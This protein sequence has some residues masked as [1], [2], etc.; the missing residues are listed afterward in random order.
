MMLHHARRCAVAE[1]LG[2]V[3]FE[4]ADAQIHPF[5]ADTFDLVVHRGNDIDVI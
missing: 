1:G 5:G 4:R 2:N 3:A